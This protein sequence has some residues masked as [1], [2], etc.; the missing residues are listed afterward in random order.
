MT[1]ARSNTSDVTLDALP[2]PPSASASNRF[3][4]SAGDAV[5]EFKV[6]TAAFDLKV[7]QTPAV[8]SISAS[9]RAPMPAR[10]R[11]LHQDGAWMT[12]K[13]SSPTGPLFSRTLPT[14]LGRFFERPVVLPKIYDGHGKT[15]SW[16]PT[17]D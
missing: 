11:L 9:N 1:G 16:S 5:S 10:H 7:G 3:L 13:T 4:C 2:I 17:K 12:A 8:W 15:F 14:T 6:Q